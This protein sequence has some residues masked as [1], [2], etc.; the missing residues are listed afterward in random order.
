MMTFHESMNMEGEIDRHLSKLNKFLMSTQEERDGGQCPV[1]DGGDAFRDRLPSSSLR[2]HSRG[3][4]EF[5]S[6]DLRRHP[7]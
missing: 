1:F 4:H 2:D 3:G 6:D 5:D 7:P